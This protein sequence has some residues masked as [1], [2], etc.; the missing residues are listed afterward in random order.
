M[1]SME[2]INHNTRPLTET[3]SEKSRGPVTDSKG[4][5]EEDG[6]SGSRK[7]GETT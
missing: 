6:I 2:T 1:G 7:A 4:R 3:Y 5:C